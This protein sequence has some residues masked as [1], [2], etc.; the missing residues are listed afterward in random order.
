MSP[1]LSVRGLHVTLGQTELVRGVEL[2]L[3]GGETLTLIGESGSG[4]TVTSLALLRLLPR[5]MRL[6]AASL[7]LSGQE[8][9]GLDEESFRE[10]RGRRMAMIFQDPVGAFN[11]AKRVSWHLRAVLARA[12]ET[13]NWRERAMAALGDVR[14]P[15]PASVLGRFP[16]QL[17]GGMLQRVLI[18]MVLALQ[19]DL[20]IADEPTTNLDNIVERQILALFQDLQAKLA[21]ALLFVTHDMTIAAMISDRIAVMYAGQIIETGPAPSVLRNPLHPY[22]RGLIQTANALEEGAERLTEIPGQPPAPTSLEPGCA[23][24]P[25][26]AHA[27]PGCELPQPAREPEPEHRVR[28]VLYD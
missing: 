15:N 14:I 20:I 3:H 2:E 21:S 9:Q 16:H 25:R 11:P 4:K 7:A 24:R 8:L 27:R 28:C 10:L 26:C 6:E 18:A 22:T 1:V 19:P 5:A 23:F 12:G 13:G 17:S